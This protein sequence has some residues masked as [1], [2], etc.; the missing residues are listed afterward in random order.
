M[1]HVR[2]SH[3]SDF[4]MT[5]QGILRSLQAV[6]SWTGT[7]RWTE[8]GGMCDISYMYTTYTCTNKSTFITI[9]QQAWVQYTQSIYVY[10]WTFMVLGTGTPIINDHLILLWLFST[11]QQH[12][13]VH[14]L[15]CIILGFRV[16]SLEYCNKWTCLNKKTETIVYFSWIPF[17][18]LLNLREYENLKR[19]SIS[20][21]KIW[22]TNVWK[23]LICEEKNG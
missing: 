23:P 18:G 6:H 22:F 5:T 20:I 14:K 9:L 19:F 10:I 11:T 2:P 21:N 12:T 13:A 17:T 8:W 1:T 15:I 3:D 4:R 16:P 7:T